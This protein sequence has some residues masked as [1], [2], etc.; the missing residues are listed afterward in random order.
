MD[1]VGYSV[2]L[3]ITLSE[4]ID[5]CLGLYIKVTFLPKM[6]LFYSLSSYSDPVL[7]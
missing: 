7:T 4:F 5:K 2:K 6:T 3:P 1:Y